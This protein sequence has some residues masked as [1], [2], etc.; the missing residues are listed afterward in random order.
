ML[1]ADWRGSAGLASPPRTPLAAS[2]GHAGCRRRIR[3][4]PRRGGRTEEGRGR[5][6]AGGAGILAALLFPRGAPTV[7]TSPPRSPTGRS[8]CAIPCSLL[9]SWRL[10]RCPCSRSYHDG[11][12][13]AGLPTASHFAAKLLPERAGVVLL[14]HA[15]AGRD[16]KHGGKMVNKFSNDILALDKKDAAGLHDPARRRRQ[17]EAL[18]DHPVP[19]TARSAFRPVRTRWSKCSRRHPSSTLD[20]IVVTGRFTVLKDDSAASSTGSPT[21]RRWRSSSARAR[22]SSRSWCR[23]RHQ[24]PRANRS[25]SQALRRPPAIC[26]WSLVSATQLR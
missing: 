16:R 12:P 24:Q 4:A 15:G 11:I 6:G 18:P 14:A 10:P 9:S 26:G 13:P 23:P 8:R 2:G 20:P 5:A 25:S 21:P 19:P 22:R 17:A 3:A 7:S 1:L